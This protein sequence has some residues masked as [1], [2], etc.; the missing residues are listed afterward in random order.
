MTL[1]ARQMIRYE[2]HIELSEYGEEKQKILL[3]SKVLVVG[4]G[5]LGCPVSVYLCAS[6]VGS[7]TIVDDDKVSLSNLQRQILYKT[8]DQKQSKAVLSKEYLEGI[9]DDCSVHAIEERLNEGNIENIMKDIDIV[10]DASDNFNTRYLLN[11]F[12]LRHKKTLI[13]GAVVHYDGQVSVFKAYEDD[14]PCYQCLYP[15]K[16]QPQDVPSCADSAVLSPVAGVIGTLMATECIKELLGIGQSI[17]G[18]INLYN[19]LSSQFTKID[20]EKRCA[21]KTCGVEVQGAKIPSEYSAER[22]F[23]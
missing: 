20:I 16:P 4:A 3:N 19:S 17:A 7:I 12:C 23:G 10:I 2:R 6:G 15:E 1:T 13:S 14:M 22:H 21:C 8:K 5:G 18:S 9:N 11:D